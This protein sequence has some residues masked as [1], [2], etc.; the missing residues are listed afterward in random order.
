MSPRS[1]SLNLVCL[2]P[3][4]NGA[5]TLKRYFDGARLFCAGVVALDD[6][7]TDETPSLLRAEPLVK[8]ILSNPSRRSYRGWND[9]E[10][11]QRLL[12]ACGDFNPDW[13]LWLDADELVAPCDVR[14]MKQFIR[15]DARRD[16]AYGF[17]V[18]RAI[19]DERHYDKSRLWVYRLFSYRKGYMLPAEQLHFEP[20]PVQIPRHRWKRTRLRLIHLAGLTA[21]T[22]RAR[23]RKY[24]EA[25]PDRRWQ[26]SYDEL[27]DPPGHVWEVRRLPR[28]LALM[29]D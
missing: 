13:V 25:D 28:N 6:G 20:V 26:G 2:L 4:R 24:L 1:A 7:S 14:G 10:N 12:D 21:T 27:L 9:A 18:L 16:A 17:Q 19:V 23:Y 8:A 5:A 11:R 22:R 29:I 15:N 3:V